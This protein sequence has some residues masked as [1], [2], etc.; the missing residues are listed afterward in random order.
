MPR[1]NCW[2]R[3]WRAHL[4]SPTNVGQASR[5]PGRAKRGHGGAKPA[6]CGAAGQAG[7]LPYV[8]GATSAS[9][10]LP[11]RALLWWRSAVLVVSATAALAVLSVRTSAAPPAVS[12]REDRILIIPKAGHEAELDR[13][14]AVERVKIYR[15]LTGLGN[16]HILELP[17]GADPQA[18]VERYRRSG[19][20]ETADLD[21]R[22][23]RPAASPNDPYFLDGHQ[24]HLHNTGQ[25]FGTPDAD[26]DASEAW[27]LQNMATNVI[28]AFTDTGARI[29][30][31]DLAPNLWTNPGES[32]GGKE[33]NNVDDDGNGYIDDVHGIN[34]VNNTGD[35]VDEYNHGTHVAGIAGA[36]G[37][38]GLGICGIAWKVQLMPLKFISGGMGT[39][40]DLAMCLD[41]ARLHGAKVI[42]SSVVSTMTSATLS[43]AYW[44]VR[45]AGIVVCAAAGNNGTDNDVLPLYPASYKMDNILAVTATDRND[46]QFDNYG[47]TSVHLGA[48]GKDIYSTWPSAD[49]AYEFNTGT[50]MAA[51]MVAGAAALLRARFPNESAQQIVARILNSVDPLPSLAGKCVTG[52]RLNLRKALDLATMPLFDFT[53]APYAWVPTNGMTS[54]SFAT[55]DSVNGPFPLPFALPFYGKSYTQIWVSA[56]GLLGVTNTGLEAGINANIPQTNAP[57]AIYP[58]WDNLNPT[59]AG[60]VWC[61][62]A[63]VAPNR[64]W[65]VS[66]VDVPHMNN[67]MT[68]FTF[69]AILHESGHVGFQYLEVETGSGTLVKG[70]SAT[71]GIEDPS[72]LF[73]SRYT[74]NGVPNLLTNTQAL[75]FTPQ[76][77]NHPAPGLQA[78]SGPL[79]GQIELC[80]S[81]EP[82]QPGA[83]LYSADLASWSMIY[84]NLLPASGLATVTDSNS[85]PQRFYRAASG[86]FLP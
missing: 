75:V 72:G 77:V 47:L 46:Q 38:N 28:V 69:Q 26:I 49:N 25:N 81:G 76:V 74:L 14:H 52:G 31:E 63:G 54:M 19:H 71:V 70:R 68:V 84:S 12:Y 5:L 4:A 37:N 7:R 85:A 41:Y 15:K 30:H 13:V 33:T 32:G 45:Q 8:H 56:N 2:N 18:L 61:G 34:A 24:W 55:G 80:L 66:W 43:N 9:V 65:V 22:M 73:A 78:Q 82:A 23:W 16:I 39:D 86:P 62:A 35:L 11:K 58:F 10:V 36:A 3:L 29:T 83:I 53:N 44:N 79:P 42:N 48:P 50:S 20:V 64:K 67:P 6:P 59:L 27:D 17:K 1:K 40:S 60:S 57:N 51:P 21:Y